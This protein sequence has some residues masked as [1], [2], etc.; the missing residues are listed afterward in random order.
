MKGGLRPHPSALKPALTEQNKYSWLLFALV[1]IDPTD[2]TKLKDMYEKDSENT[3]EGQQGAG[4]G[5][6]IVPIGCD[7]VLPANCCLFN[8]LFFQVVFPRIHWI[9]CSRRKDSAL[10]ICP[11]VTFFVSLFLCS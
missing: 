11:V 6:L 2:P 7:W 9:F 5:P 3:K 4:Y 1:M 10:G 8:L